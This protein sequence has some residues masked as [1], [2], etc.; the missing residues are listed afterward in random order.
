[1]DADKIRADIEPRPCARFANRFI[2]NA[3]LRAHLPHCEACRTA[4]L[5]LWRV[6]DKLMESRHGCRYPLR[7]VQIESPRTQSAGGFDSA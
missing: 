1:M 2:L 7:I 6:S 4:V 3:R 5:Y